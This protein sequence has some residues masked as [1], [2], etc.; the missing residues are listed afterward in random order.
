MN[1]IVLGP[2]SLEQTITAA[3]GQWPATRHG[4][5]APGWQIDV[6]RAI[7]REEIGQESGVHAAVDE[8]RHRAPSQEAQ[9]SG[10]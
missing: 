1:L 3:R 6:G 5:Y 10:H 4:G 8:N 2:G 9:I 7:R